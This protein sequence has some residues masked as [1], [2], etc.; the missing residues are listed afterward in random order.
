MAASLHRR[1]RRRPGRRSKGGGGA[2][3][4]AAAPFSWRLWR[5]RSFR[6]PVAAAPGWPPLLGS[7]VRFA[8]ASSSCCLFFFFSVSLSQGKAK[9]SYCLILAVV[10][11]AV[12]RPLPFWR[13][14]WLVFLFQACSRPHHDHP[15]HD[16]RSPLSSFPTPPTSTASSPSPASRSDVCEAP[17]PEALPPRCRRR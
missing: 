3:A 13:L 12:A 10:P 16:R 8:F 17:P 5:F 9:A 2:A 6:Q 1:R 14:A 11:T 7:P 4:A 15:R